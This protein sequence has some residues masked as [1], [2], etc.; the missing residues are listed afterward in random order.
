MNVGIKNTKSTLL[1]S[2]F[3]RWSSSACAL[4]GGILLA[5]KT[6]VSGYGF[7]ALALSSSQML[8]ASILTKDKVMIV[9]SSSLFIFV[10]CMG[11]YRWVLI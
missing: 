6:E 5:S 1:V 4:I 8:I 3:L 11:I 2:S 10:D 7:V 9:Y